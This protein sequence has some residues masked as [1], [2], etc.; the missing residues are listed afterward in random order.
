MREGGGRG[1]NICGEK[2]GEGWDVRDRK[3]RVYLKEG[4][5][6]CNNGGGCKQG[7]WEKREEGRE[8]R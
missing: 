4:E 7:N 1:R 5:V 6:D 3:G 8:G 2:R